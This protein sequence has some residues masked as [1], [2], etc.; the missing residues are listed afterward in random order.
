MGA[1]PAGVFRE[2]DTYFNHPH[3]DF[4]KSDEALRLRLCQNCSILTYKGPRLS[5][6]AKTRVEYEVP[7][8]DMETMRKVLTSLGFIESGRVFKEREKYRLRDIEIAIDS[9]EGLGDFVELE[10]RGIDREKA[11]EELFALAI[12]LGLERFETKSYLELLHT[13]L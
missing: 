7:V 9:V 4:R 3:R 6:R 11:E 1:E 2:N 13:G 5:G 8:G 10:K 12:E